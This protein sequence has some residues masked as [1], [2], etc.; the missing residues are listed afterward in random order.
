MKRSLTNEDL[1]IPPSDD[2]S[3]VADLLT[4]SLPVMSKMV[5]EKP[6][7]EP[8]GFINGATWRLFQ[9]RHLKHISAA[10]EA[11]Q[12]LISEM[13]QTMDQRLNNPDTH[14]EALETLRQQVRD[15]RPVLRRG[16]QAVESYHDVL[17][18]DRKSANSYGA[19][20]AALMSAISKVTDDKFNFAAVFDWIGE[21]KQGAASMDVCEPPPVAKAAPAAAPKL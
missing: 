8:E 4:R 5:A 20:T 15:A 18:E 10:V 9:R 19:D 21:G 1:S 7:S 17:L 13:A 11:G 16:M 6:G 2:F 14:R 3:K 12:G